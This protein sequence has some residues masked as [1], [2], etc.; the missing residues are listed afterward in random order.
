MYNKRLLTFLYQTLSN[1]HSPHGQGKYSICDIDILFCIQIIIFRSSNIWFLHHHCHSGNIKTC[2]KENVDHLYVF[3]CPLLV[4]TLKQT[5]SQYADSWSETPRHVAW[6]RCHV[7]LSHT[8][9]KRR[10]WIGSCTWLLVERTGT[11]STSPW[12]TLRSAWSNQLLYQ[13]LLQISEQTN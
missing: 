5:Q 11:V 8:P 7:Y 12:R 4:S 3:T 13:S 9:G 2:H 10:T 1:L 6:T